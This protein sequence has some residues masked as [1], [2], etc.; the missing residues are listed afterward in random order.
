[1]Q[2]V[3]LSIPLDKA[4]PNKVIIS[5]CQTVND[6]NRKIKSMMIGEIP[7]EELEEN[8]KSKDILKNEDEKNMVNNWILQTMKKEIK[9]KK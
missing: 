5:L 6:L 8:L 7:E 9:K 2:E 3:F 1:M 4:D